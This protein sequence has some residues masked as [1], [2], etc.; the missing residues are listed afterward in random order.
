[1]ELHGLGTGVAA[2][3]A[4]VFIT[5]LAGGFADARGA[6]ATSLSVAPPT[7]HVQGP[8]LVGNGVAGGAIKSRKIRVSA[9][10]LQLEEGVDMSLAEVLAVPRGTGGVTKNQAGRVDGANEALEGSEPSTGLVAT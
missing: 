4:T 7:I 6:V 5:L 9:D 10:A 1:M 2:A 8:E 3:P